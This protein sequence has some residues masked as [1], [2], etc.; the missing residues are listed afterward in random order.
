M[1]CTLYIK[2]HVM[3][4]DWTVVRWQGRALENMDILTKMKGRKRKAGGK[5]LSSLCDS[6][7]MKVVMVTPA[8]FGTN[9]RGNYLLWAQTRVSIIHNSRK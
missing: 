6:V 8:V 1:N 7:P 5:D 9:L 3:L 4:I 2:N